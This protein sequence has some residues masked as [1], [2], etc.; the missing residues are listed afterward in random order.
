MAYHIKARFADLCGIEKNKL[1]VYIKRGKV[2]CSGD[3]IDDGL[4]INQEFIEKWQV[5]TGMREQEITVKEPVE[6]LQTKPKAPNIQPPIYPKQKIPNVQEPEFHFSGNQLDKQ[7]KE[8]DLERKMEELEIAKLKRQK[9]AG[10][11]MP[12]DLVKKSSLSFRLYKKI[13]TTKSKLA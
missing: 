11:S 13:N 6:Q 12:T 10:E 4:A 1:A 5:K 8:V 9:M 2:I 3:L 7:I